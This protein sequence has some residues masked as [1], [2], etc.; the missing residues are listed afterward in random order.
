MLKFYVLCSGFCLLKAT[1]HDAGIMYTSLGFMPSLLH[2]LAVSNS[3]SSTSTVCRVREIWPHRVTN[4]YIPKPTHGLTVPNLMWMS[5]YS[6]Y[7]YKCQPLLCPVVI[8]SCRV[9]EIWSH[10]MTNAYRTMKHGLL[11][12]LTAPIAM[13]MSQCMSMSL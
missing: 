5:W 2:V 13:G 7:P 11:Q 3:I 12:G 6:T 9:Q 1:N 10:K 8:L 4:A